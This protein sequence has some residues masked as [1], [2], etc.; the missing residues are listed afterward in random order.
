MLSEKRR[1][2]AVNTDLTSLRTFFSRSLQDGKKTGVSTHVNQ[3]VSL[4]LCLPFFIRQPPSDFKNIF[5]K[6]ANLGSNLIS[7]HFR[8]KQA[9][10]C[11]SEGKRRTG[12]AAPAEY[13]GNINII[14]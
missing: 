12:P 13:F 7:Q 3:S 1:R 4:L 9:N 14:S 10:A 6:E 11:A 8:G 5:E 2:G